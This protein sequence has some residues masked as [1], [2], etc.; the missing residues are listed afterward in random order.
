MLP[1][2]RRFGAHLPLGAG[3]VRAAE[4]AH[5]RVAVCLDTAHLWGAGYDIS[6]PAGVDRVLASFGSTIGFE[7]LAMVHLNDSSK[8]LGSRAD[9]HEHIG[10]GR[11]GPA[12]LG[13]MLRHPGL[14][15][16]TY[17]LETPGTKDG[18]DAVN[19][20]RMLALAGDVEGAARLS[21]GPAAPR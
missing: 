21:P 8:G 4:R 11:I 13:A 5:R 12:G 18:F 6:G 1:D 10:R 9:R 16:R 15:G 7:R 14:A 19:A 20:A 17:Y 2:G 3:M